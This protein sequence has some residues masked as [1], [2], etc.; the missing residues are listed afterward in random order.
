MRCAQRDVPLPPATPPADTIV[1]SARSFAVSMPVALQGLCHSI[2]LAH[3]HPACHAHNTLTTHAFRR[4]SVLPDA[5]PVVLQLDVP[6]VSRRWIVYNPVF[7]RLEVKF[8]VP[9]V[10]IRPSVIVVVVPP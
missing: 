9:S 5:A 3:Q 1:P 2:L 6:R 4:R 10:L 8:S 7:S